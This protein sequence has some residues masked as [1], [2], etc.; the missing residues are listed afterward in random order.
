MGAERADTGPGALARCLD[1]I[2]VR[3][4]VF[5]LR[6]GELIRTASDP[7]EARDVCQA[8]RQ[9]LSRERLSIANRWM[10]DLYPLF[11]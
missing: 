9:V 2:G 7:G 6:L 11:R 8:I 3:Q 1:E 4:E 10:G 5:D